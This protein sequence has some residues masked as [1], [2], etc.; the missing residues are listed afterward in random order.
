MNIAERQVG[1]I[2]VLALSGKIT[3]EDSGQLKEK[4]TSVLE[5]GQKRIVLDLGGVNY[6][7]SSGLGEMVSCHT[8]ASRQNAS[9]KLANLGT[10]SKDLLVMTK[11]IMVFDVYDSEAAAI[12][13][14]EQPV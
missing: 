14:F 7:D 4:V 13:S 5:Q 11:L 8:T 10:R 9:V 6:I 12:A 3:L 2:T 1:S